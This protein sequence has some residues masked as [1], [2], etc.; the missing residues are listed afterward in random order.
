MTVDQGGAVVQRDDY[1]PFGLTFNSWSTT[2]PK[3]RY[4]FNGVKFDEPTGMYETLFRGYDPALGRFAQID[5]LSD[6]MSGISPYHFG[7]S[8]LG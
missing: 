2:N 4:K 5:P 8:N 3:N 6:F 1:Y 7:F